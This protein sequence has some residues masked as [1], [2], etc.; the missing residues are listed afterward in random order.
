MKS[1]AGKIDAFNI[2]FNQAFTSP[3]G[4]KMLTSNR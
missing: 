1:V 3:V 2:T 4:C